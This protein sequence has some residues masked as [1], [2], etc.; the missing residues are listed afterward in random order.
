MVII[1]GLVLLS[2][3]VCY[4]RLQVHECVCEDDVEHSVRSAALFVHVCGCNGARFISL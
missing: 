4:P 2:V 1:E 3:S